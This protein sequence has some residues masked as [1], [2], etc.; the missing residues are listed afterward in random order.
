MLLNGYLFA[1]V[2]APLIPHNTT[3]DVNLRLLTKTD[4]SLQ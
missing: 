3:N 1:N 2:T 4:I